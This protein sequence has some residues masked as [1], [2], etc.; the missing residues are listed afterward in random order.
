MVRERTNGRCRDRRRQPTRCLL[1]GG[2]RD[3]A[4]RS[5]PAMTEHTVVVP[6]FGEVSTFELAVPCEVFGIDRSE[7]GV[8][9][10]R[11][12]VCA[13][14]GRPL[15][16]V[17]GMAISTPHDLTALRRADTV[18]VPAYK[19]SGPPP[20]PELFD[21]LRKA[22]ARG[23]RIASLC[24][25]AFALAEAGLLN[26]R[27]A[28]THWMYA[29]R[30]AAQYPEIDVDPSVLYVQD[31][32]VFTSA[33]TAAAIDLCLHL[34]RLDHGAEVANVFARRMVVPPHRD[35]GQAQFVE[36]PVPVAPDDDD[37]GPTMTW[38]LEHLAEPIT[39][40][41]L[42]AMANMAPRTFARRFRAVAGT[43]PLQW[44]LNQRVITAQR[45]LETTD[46]PVDWIADR[47]GFGTAATLRLH[48][49]RIVGTS[50]TAY[51][52]SFQGGSSAE[53]SE[54]S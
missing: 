44:L 43:T 35:G 1:G 41:R 30:L 20:P 28:T 47:C 52:V 26:G 11:F 16:A 23:A 50:P 13:P 32:N 54:A 2:W 6:I 51:R 9:R 37:L 34:V 3:P 18:I 5:V 21:A 36:A 29:D 15:P 31:G 45:L 24:S 48:F 8:P 19:M 14:D 42:A 10:Y 17:G 27:R 38:A 40:E 39:V 22:H 7:M 33:G 53:R 25:G 46:V 49:G 4:V 12:I